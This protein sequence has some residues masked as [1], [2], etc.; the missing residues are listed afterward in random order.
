M[1]LPKKLKDI[2]VIKEKINEIN[3][4]VIE[5]F[6]SDLTNFKKINIELLKLGFKINYKKIVFY[7][8]IKKVN[9]LKLIFKRRKNKEMYKIYSKFIK[10]TT[11][12][13]FILDKKNIKKSFKEILSS[14]S[15]WN[16]LAIDSEN[17]PVGIL[18]LEKYN[19]YYTTNLI[20]VDEKYR[21][22]GYSY[23]LLKKAEQEFNKKGDK[24]F[25]Y[26]STWENDL[27]MINAFKKYGFKEKRKMYH[28][29]KE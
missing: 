12:P 24:K 29:I 1:I 8:K 11:A 28:Y 22:N 26:E 16:F 17:N 6:W 25:W 13:D 19:N 5:D 2:K 15:K 9:D 21:G 23:E 20:L 4:F 18:I 27:P 14:K 7:K 3:N 10:N